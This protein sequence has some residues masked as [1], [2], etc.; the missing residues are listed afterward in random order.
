MKTNKILS[1]VLIILLMFTLVGTVSAAETKNYTV[2]F[3]QVK[4]GQV[5]VT[6]KFN[7]DLPTDFDQKGWN[8][9]DSKTITKTFK[10]GAYEVFSMN[11]KTEW[12]D[13]A[14]PFE[15]EVGKKTNCLTELTDYKSSDSS[16]LKIQNGEII[17]V[18]EGKATIT[19]K[20]TGSHVS[21]LEFEGN[22]KK[23]SSN[24]S[25]DTDAQ[26]IKIETSLTSL[27]NIKVETNLT[28]KDDKQ[29]YIYISKKAD[30]NVTS[31]TA[32]V[33][34]L[35]ANSDGKLC[36][37]IS[38][39]YCELVGTNYA[40][41]IEKTFSSSEEKVI[42]KGKKIEDPQLPSLGNRL[43]IWLYDVNKTGVTNKI[44]M[45]KDRTIKYK[46][47]KVDSNDILK[48]FKNESSDKAFSKLLEYS[49]N[50]KILKEGSIT[51]DGLDYNLIK[52]V[53]IEN[54]GYYFVY[55]DAD[56]QNGKYNKLEDIAIYTESNLKEGNALVHF[57]FADIKL[58]EEQSGNSENKEQNQEDNTKSNK[59]I[60]QTG[61]KQTVAIAM[62]TI[63]I[64]GVAC[65]IG[66][67]KY[68]GIK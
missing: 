54:G 41:I 21:V 30:E 42:L 26:N 16:V 47:G 14:V 49:K 1:V 4:S 61:D 17:A 3:G 51:V 62:G 15:L 46:I 52:D 34:A 59:K 36:A 40:Y 50:A 63:A 6:V 7:N 28:K 60:P 45:S 33:T 9:K 68:N 25:D 64:I 27:A 39:N 8:K 22:V 38:K 43:D 5:D 67:K 53:N 55:M 58:K 56:T 37:F 2:T 11:G 57:S 32:G 29:Y 31:K 10:Q 65:Y 48:S 12:V 23:A 44:S 24:S 35:S 19:A 18:S 20:T 13:I 66:Y